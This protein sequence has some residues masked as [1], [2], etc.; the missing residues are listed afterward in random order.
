M[1]KLDAWLFK[2]LTAIV[3][4][5]TIDG[6]GISGLGGWD[7]NAYRSAIGSGRVKLSAA[8]EMEQQFPKTEHILIM[9]GG[10][11][12]EQHEW[13][14]VSYF[15]GR[16][17]LTMTVNVILSADG[18]TIARVAGEPKFFLSVCGEV[19]ADGGATYLGARYQ[20]FG[21]D[22]WNEFRD[23]E[24]DLNFL[25]PGHDGSMLP[26]FDEFADSVQQSRRVWR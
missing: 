26:R 24:F 2:M 5:G 8:L 21:I 15:G 9:Y 19:T 3:L 11:G 22:K 14:T 1:P 7:M 12:S 16:Y 13:Q 6:C 17:E 18:K 25:D 10:T 4:L 23:S 20:T